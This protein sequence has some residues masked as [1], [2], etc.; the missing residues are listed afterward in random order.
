MGMFDNGIKGTVPSILVILG[1]A[2]AAPIVLPAV[3][4]V[5]RPL[6]KTLI[7]G[8]L[9]LADTVKEYA[10]EAAEQ[11][12]DLVAECQAERAQ[13]AGTVPPEPPAA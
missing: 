1:V 4:A 8:Y 9:A 13:A 11:I 12:S 6:A 2:L 5:S 7:K 10:A 3:A